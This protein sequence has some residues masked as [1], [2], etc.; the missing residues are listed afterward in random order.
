[1]T[2][3]RRLQPFIQQM[4]DTMASVIPF[5]INIVD[6]EQI[7]VAG[8]GR[9]RGLVGSVNPMSACFGDVLASGMSQA[10]GQPGFHPICHACANE[11]RCFCFGALLYPIVWEGQTI[12]LISLLTFD[13]EQKSYLL[14]KEVSLLDTCSRISGLLTEIVG[15][16]QRIEGLQETVHLLHAVLENLPIGVLAVDQNGIVSYQ[17]EMASHLG[18]KGLLR[19]VAHREATVEPGYY[20]TGISW[21]WAAV[22]PLP[23]GVGN[24][25]VAVF[26][27]PENIWQE[28]DPPP[29]PSPGLEDWVGASYPVVLARERALSSAQNGQVVC[30]SGESGTGKRLLAH[31]IHGLSAR[32]GKP[33]VVFNCAQGSAERIAVDLFGLENPQ[34]LAWS[35]GKP[36]RFELAAGGTLFLAGIESINP[37]LQNAL[38]DVLRYKCL[39]RVGG[40]HSVPVDVRLIVST[41]TDLSKKVEDKEFRPDL[42]YSLCAMP[43]A[44]PA[45]R[46]R[47]EDIEALVSYFVQRL[48]GYNGREIHEVTHETLA[49]LCD[50]PWPGNVAELLETLQYALGQEQGPK[51]SLSSLPANLRQRQGQGQAND[52]VVRLQ[53]GVR[54]VESKILSEALT[55][56]GNSTQAKEQI[57]EML[58]ISR[59]TLYRKLKELNILLP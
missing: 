40:R 2:R 6:I 24:G 23:S 8:T 35:G 25:M 36:G 9:F 4:A 7:C 57:A 18:N 46:E 10:L 33:F 28:T 45:L 41:K 53:Q 55:R 13:A 20:W 37:D 43:I 1:M 59:A 16:L 32:A 22:A 29:G 14:E 3:L 44:L 30:I 56:Y 11:G 52:L 51:L 47:K 54:E 31:I 42:Y 5:E 34:Q 27:A 39:V 26:N 17:N 15:E 58:G 48:R 21:L 12:G 50:Y 19:L 38:F 49:A